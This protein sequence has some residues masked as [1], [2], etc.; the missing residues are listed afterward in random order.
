MITALRSPCDGAIVHSTERAQECARRAQKWTLAA[1]ILAS[2]MVFIDG[3]VVN[4][5]LPTLQES[6][7]IGPSAAQWVVEVYTLALSSLV[8]V[9]GALGD[10]FG[11]R[12]V[13]SIGIIVFALAS[14]GCGLAQ[15]A[16]E[17]VAA[18][19]VQ[20]LGGA[21]LVPGSLAIIGATFQK[22]ERAGAFGAWSSATAITSLAGPLL[23]GGLIAIAGWRAVF[24]INAPFALATL[25]ITLRHVPESRPETGRRPL[26]WAGALLA[27]AGLFGITYGLIEWQSDGLSARVAATL[28][29]A[30][31]LLVVFLLV[32]ARSHDPMVELALFR[33][34]TFSG[35]NLLTLLLYAAVGGALF[36]VPF[37]LIEVQ[38][39]SSLHA[40]WALIPL[41]LPMFVLSRAS[42]RL[43]E[44]F[45][46]R[47]L[48]VLGPLIAAAGF[49]LFALPGVGG[50]YFT[51]FFP[52]L[53]TLGVGMGITVAPLTT[54][55]MSAVPKER[56]GVAS[57]INN[58]IARAA[59]LIAI[60]AF[61][62]VHNPTLTPEGSI[63]SYVAGFRTVML[64]AA[65][66]A[67][68]SA[69][70]ARVLIEERAAALS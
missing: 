50:S 51:T 6:L 16:F 26:D 61:G 67:A 69:I 42:E 24:F 36:F 31:G 8:L 20:G 66:L 23:G 39:Y 9:G 52:P 17:L 62:I 12:R 40:G 28:G 25:F 55:V 13:F 68:G 60:A 53:A 57:G 35:A 59:G 58:A 29:I 44:R 14:L 5:V 64:L 11:R 48:M 38:G 3:S 21:M 1:T 63:D 33:S 37:N 45:G 41:I 56:S 19:A 49:G 30:V 10:H 4:L 34:R 46:T 15:N 32:E 2:S 43:V 65:L 7:G 54:A 22:E 47:R 70:T 27:T 18:R